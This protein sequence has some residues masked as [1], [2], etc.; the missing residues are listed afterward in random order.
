MENSSSYVVCGCPMT[1]PPIRSRA[2]WVDPLLCSGETGHNCTMM[3]HE[4][5]CQSR[6]PLSHSPMLSITTKAPSIRLRTISILGG[7]KAGRPLQATARADGLMLKE[8]AQDR[9]QAFA[10]VSTCTSLT[11]AWILILRHYARH[12]NRRHRD[13]HRDLVGALQQESVS[14][15]KTN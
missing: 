5:G 6:V 13:W 8:M 2:P 12:T 10:R 1:F 14:G 9:Q 11:E 3:A 4:I 15:S 7:S